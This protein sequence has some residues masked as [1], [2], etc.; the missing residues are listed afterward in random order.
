[1]TLKKN[2]IRSWAKSLFTRKKKKV[3]RD[4]TDKPLDHVHDDEEVIEEE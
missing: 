1:M 4:E 3:K 2:K